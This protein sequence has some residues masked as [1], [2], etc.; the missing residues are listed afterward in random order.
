MALA[1][2][3][4][5][6]RYTVTN[7]SRTVANNVR[8]RNLLPEQLAFVSA[9]SRTGALLVESEGENRT[10]FI[11]QWESLA[12][13]QSVQVILSTR[14]ASELPAGAVIDNLAVAFADNAAGYTAGVSI[15]LPPAIL[16]FFD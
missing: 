8:L 10:V 11:V 12:P 13:G 6:I 2:E 7:P 16:P 4:V 9:D 5:E 15:G 14:I 1:G 3:P